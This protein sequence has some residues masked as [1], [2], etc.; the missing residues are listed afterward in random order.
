M[1][2]PPDDPRTAQIRALLDGTLDADADPRSLFDVALDDEEAIQFDILRISA[3]LAQV[4]RETTK[5]GAPSAS[6]SADPPVANDLVRFAPRVALERARLAFYTR[7][8]AERAG[9]LAAQ[10]EKR[11]DAQPQETDAERQA[12][13]V[14][15]EHGRRQK[16]KQAEQERALEAARTARSELERAV[17]E[18]VARLIGVE[19]DVEVAREQLDTRRQEIAERADEVVGW[20]RRAREAKTASGIE[21]D[22]L[23]DALR[24]RLRAS[25]EAL[26]EALEALEEAATRI[27]EVGPD[28]LRDLAADP[29]VEAA[30]ARR[31]SL[32][33]AVRE[34][35]EEERSLRGEVAASL[36]DE[37]DTLNRERL[38]LLD[39]LSPEK[40]AATVGFTEIGFEQARSEALHLRLMFRY[41]WDVVAEWLRTTRTAGSVKVMPVW[42][43][44]S[45]LVP[46]LIVG[47]LFRWLRQRV[48]PL[49]SLLEKRIA[50]QDRTERRESPR[51]SRRVVQFLHGTH[52]PLEWM[53]FFAVLVWLLPSDAQRLLE[54]QLAIIVVGWALGGSLAV[55]AVN[56]LAALAAPQQGTRDTDTTDAL[57]FRSLRLV[58]G[59]IVVFALVLV[60]SARLVGKGTLYSWVLS[61]CWLAGIP[62]FL[63]LV[64]WWRDTVFERVE[65]ARRKSPV[66]AWVLSNRAGW[67]SFVAAMVGGTHLFVLGALRTGKKWVAEFEVARRALAYLFKRDLDRMSEEKRSAAGE[68]LEAEVLAKL[69]P[70]RDSPTWIECPSDPQLA[71]LRAR[72]ASRKGG[73]V[74]IVGPRGSGKS[75]LLRWLASDAGASVFVT[76]DSMTSSAAL[77]REITARSTDGA[78]PDLVVLD[79]ANAL[80]KTVLRGLSRFDLVMADARAASALWVLAIDDVIWPFLTRARDGRPLFDEVHHLPPW[81]DEQIGSLLMHRSREAGLE[82]TFEDLLEKLAPGADEIERQEALEARRV[83]YFR[84]IWDYAR[85]NPALALQAWRTSLRRGED[86]SVR[87]RSLQA[88]DAGGLEL[89]PDPACFVLRAVLQMTPARRVDIAEATRLTEG[90]VEAALSFGRAQGYFVDE[91]G[92]VRV[93]WSWLRAVV[94]FLERR[95]LL[96]KS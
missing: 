26:A 12:R 25:R 81:S 22:A 64:R 45:V 91:G 72:L 54:V 79:E 7:T 16:E 24:G 90:H 3:L 20:Q 80:I 5:L 55:N 36:L 60:L 83:G 51:R 62:V 28:P 40:R 15:E 33:Q 9:L 52:R 78:A 74:A 70:D 46:W 21:A 38:A 11:L 76:C 73:V 89:L 1:T 23:Y 43:I 29:A 53:A 30:R 27:P 65:R 87:V 14:E 58:G 56:T 39:F 69:A 75:T 49:L 59:V 92:G 42:R 71:A 96:V 32:D 93:A 57:R 50:E 19:R 77:R 85:G 18:E 10:E 47:L 61:T 86:G 44:A 41:H 35:R 8:A 6:A 4:E 2:A 68:S 34:A 82:P 84:M 37:I 31:A 48:G 88:P 94:Q 63:L 67:K 13:E 66:Q 95:H 17:G